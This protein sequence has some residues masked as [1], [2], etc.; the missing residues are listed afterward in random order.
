[1]N[2]EGYMRIGSETKG[3][4]IMKHRIALEAVLCVI[5]L[6]AGAGTALAEM[7][8]NTTPP[9]ATGGTNGTGYVSPTVPEI[10]ND[11]PTN[12]VIHS[13]YSANTDACASCH[14][15]HTAVGAALLQWAD[16]STAC[17]ACHDGTVTTTY[18]VQE[19]EIV[20][21]VKT[22][23]GLFG[24]GGEV[25]LSN[26]NISGSQTTSAAMGG[27]E[28][29]ATKDAYGDWSTTFDCAACH[30]PHGQGGNDRILQADPNG[31]AMQ[32][33]VVGETLTLQS[34][35][36]YKAAKADWIAGYPYSAETKIFVGGVQQTTGFTIDYRNGT[37]TF[38]SAPGGTVTADYVP[39]IQ[40]EITVTN[41]LTSTEQVAYVSGMNQFCGACHTDYNTAKTELIVDGKTIAGQTLSGVYRKAYRHGV[42]MLWNDAT[43]GTSVLSDGKLK[44][45]SISGSSGTVTCLTC[46]YAHGTDDDFAGGTTYDTSRSTALKRQPN[47]A[48][49]ESCHQKG[50]VSSY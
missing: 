10:M 25:G 46:H 6:I 45:E 31:I 7:D 38:S 8:K 13:N 40:V 2:A 18:N 15:T 16:T 5:F 21:G 24:N 43:H 32:N 49:C 14:S 48:V 1:M 33:K 47:M 9:L 41:K 22:F 27:S 42:G 44:F 26:H 17:M 4:R 35:T 12:P 30:T 20:A 39:G 3:G 28:N 23:G 34:G 36:T 37:V 29:A 11:S 50:P 19:G